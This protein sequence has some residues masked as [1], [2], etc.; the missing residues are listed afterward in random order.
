VSPQRQ[1]EILPRGV[2]VALGLGCW[3]WLLLS[4]TDYYA[5]MLTRTMIMAILP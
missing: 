2:Q 5:E 1:P 4:A 3:R